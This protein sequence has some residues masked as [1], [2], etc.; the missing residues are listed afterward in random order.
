MSSFLFD[1]KYLHPISRLI[2]VNTN[3]RQLLLLEEVRARHAVAFRGNAP[4]EASRV[5]E[6]GRV[7]GDAATE[8]RQLDCPRASHGRA[9][10][11][12]TSPDALSHTDAK[13][14]LEGAVS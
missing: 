12:E 4:R 10:V 2:R 6:T 8:S 1:L 7:R 3:P 11:Q 5:E 9:E 13:S 14:L